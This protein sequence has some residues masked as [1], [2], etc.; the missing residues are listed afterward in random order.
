M[1]DQSDIQRSQD[2]AVC[3][4]IYG[5]F[6]AL[7]KGHDNLT[8][9]KESE[10]FARRDS[11]DTS[12][13]Y[14]LALHTVKFIV[15][16]QRRRHPMGSDLLEDALMSAL[17]RANRAAELF[18]PSSDNRFMAYAG[19]FIDGALTDALVSHLDNVG[20]GRAAQYD[21]NALH[22][23]RYQFANETDNFPTE[24]EIEAALGFSPDRIKFLD[25]LLGSRVETQVYDGEGLALTSA[26]EA[27]E[28]RSGDAYDALEASL[29]AEMIERAKGNMTEKQREAFE[30]IV[31]RGMTWAEAREALG[32]SSN[33]AILQ[34]IDGAR[35]RVA[36]E[37]LGE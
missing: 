32:V 7:G 35:A 29:Q 9:E 17:F 18:D 26:V 8:A 3:Q 31:E 19:R 2:K 13:S 27:I 21:A 34:R 30:L 16:R 11:G 15:Q 20:A 37:L 22:K 6:V 24:E 36:K 12:A 5:R 28:D 1:S 10:L 23:F 4:L 14:E 33:Q 25:G